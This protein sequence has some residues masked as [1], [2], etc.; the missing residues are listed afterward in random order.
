MPDV[1]RGLAGSDVRLP[2]AMPGSSGELIGF[3]PFIESIEP[4]DASDDGDGTELKFVFWIVV[5]VLALGDVI[6]GGAVIG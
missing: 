1:I 4:I 3:I 2:M 5:G 6:D